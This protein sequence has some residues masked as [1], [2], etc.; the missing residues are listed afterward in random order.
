MS[1]DWVKA[2]RPRP[3]RK[4][5]ISHAARAIEP[6]CVRGFLPGTSGWSPLLSSSCSA[7]VTIFDIVFTVSIGYAPTLDS[8]DSMT[9][10]A[11]SR[12]ALATSE[13]SARVGR[14]LVI[15][16]SI[17]WVAT[18]TGLAL[19]RRQLDEALLHHGDLLERV[20]DGQVA[21]G[22]HDGV[23]RRDDVLHVLHG[24]RLLHL[25]DDGD[26]AA[27]LVHHPVDV[28]HVLG[29]PHEG[30]R[31]QVG[32]HP[33]REPQVVDVL[34]AQRGHVDGRAG[35]VDALVVGDDAAL[36]DDRLH[37]R[38]LDVQDL[39]LDV[40]VVDEDLVA[41][42]DVARQTLVR[43]AADRLVAGDVLGG[44]GELVTAHQLDRTLGEGLKAD[45]RALEVGEDTDGPAGLLGGGPDP[46]VAALVLGVGAVAE[47]EAGH[48]HAGL[49]QRH[50]HFVGVDRGAESTDDFRTAHGAI[51]SVCFATEYSVWWKIQ[52]RGVVLSCFP[53]Q[54]VFFTSA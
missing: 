14:E 23:E 19:R 20:L 22:H 1:P 16:D 26:P 50:E 44:D 21:T 13:A 28:G 49:D 53:A 31:D 9:A 43:R 3:P 40:A 38:A 52:M 32:A 45:L 5:E 30:Q 2:T 39:Q 54:F 46:V 10:S 7:A 48:V 47:V 4:S 15:I 11:P 34:L 25:G 36:D 42:R 17:I 33:Q 8:A 41:A 27:L 35:Q 18:I 51:L 6:P 29:V 24:L 12:I 37:P